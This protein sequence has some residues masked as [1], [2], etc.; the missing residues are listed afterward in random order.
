M[1]KKKLLEV[2]EQMKKRKPNFSR[3]DGTKKARIEDDVWRLA[4]GCDNK[5]RLKRK[6]HKKTPSSGYRG[7]VAVRGLDADTGLMPVVVENLPAL[8]KLKKSEHGIIVSG[9]TGD[10]KRK[11]ILQEASKLGLTVLNLEI[12]KAVT[13][14]DQKLKERQ[15]HKKQEDEAKKAE[16]DKKAADA[17]KK[18]DAKD[19][20]AADKKA[21]AAPAAEEA[22][23]EEKKAAEKEEKDKV[24]T[25]KQ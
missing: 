19:K 4:R 25:Q 20:K 18:Q 21:A 13:A 6:G 16:E 9:K 24:L 23:E 12:A 17:K 11:L 7:P 8:A 14:I 10:F 15:S 22:S 5:H 1:D 3:K 2:R